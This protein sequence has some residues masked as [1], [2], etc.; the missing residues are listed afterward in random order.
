[1]SCARR[2]A[3]CSAMSSISRAARRRAATRSASSPTPSTGGDAGRGG[4]RATLPPQLALGLTRVAD[5][6]RTSAPRDLAA[7]RACRARASPRSRPTCCTATAPRAAPMRGWRQR[8]AR[9]ASTRRTAAACT[10]AGTRRVGLFYLALERVL[11]RRTDLFLFES[12][13]GRDAFT[14]KVGTPAG[15][16]ARGAQRRHARPNSPPVA[17]DADATDLVFVGELR[18]LKGIDVLI[19]AIA[20]LARDGPHGQRHHRRRRPGRAGIRSAQ[21]ARARARRR[22][23]LSRPDA[24]ARGVRARPDAGRAVARGIAALHRAR[25]RRRRN[26]DDRHRCRRDPGDLRAGC[27]PTWCRR[28]TRRRWRDAI[29][30]GARRTRP[31][32]AIGNAAPASARARRVF[33]RRR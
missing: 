32:C 27:R 29:A 7:H 31:R 8:R 12:A 1:M 4:A 14:A 22:G 20:L 33:G 10:T 15:A 6:P 25:G 21:V 11:M 5:E 17:P 24:G 28:A 30:R 16:R 3:A 19:E 9:S 26:A 13:Y 23:A 18:M 2:S